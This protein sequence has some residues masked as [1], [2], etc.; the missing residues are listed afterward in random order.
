MSADT[1]VKTRQ[2]LWLARRLGV[3]GRH[4]TLGV[5]T[6]E[7]RKARMRAAVLEVGGAVIAGRGQDRKPFTYAE[8]F[9]RLYH[10]PLESTK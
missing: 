7:E 8:A 6:A 10:E 9:E 2:E 4:V 3:H 5:T 1:I